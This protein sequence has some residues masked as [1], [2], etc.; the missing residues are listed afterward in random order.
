MLAVASLLLPFLHVKRRR[1]EIIIEYIKHREA[2][3]KM[4]KE[5]EKERLAL[6]GELASL[7]KCGGTPE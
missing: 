7:N 2:E 3:G 1:A 6:F 5:R 4:G